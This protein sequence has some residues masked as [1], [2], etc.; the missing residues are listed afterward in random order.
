MVDAILVLG[1]LNRHISEFELY[2]GYDSD[3]TNNTPCPG[4]PFAYPVTN[5]YG[6]LAYG[7]PWVN[8]AEAWCA[9][10]GMYVS[11]VREADAQPSLS[12]IQLCTFGVIA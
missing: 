9:L 5:D 12:V 8:G 4:G 3:H 1:Y 11:F 10:D 6:T 2:V 7:T